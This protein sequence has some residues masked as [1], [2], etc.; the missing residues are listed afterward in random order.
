MLT[1]TTV[2]V[3]TRVVRRGQK[4]RKNAKVICESSLNK[5]NNA[6]I[7]FVG[8][9]LYSSERIKQVKSY[10]RTYKSAFL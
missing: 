2:K 8:Q 10:Y 3:Q 1:F 4:M 9:S 5:L 7:N 6:L